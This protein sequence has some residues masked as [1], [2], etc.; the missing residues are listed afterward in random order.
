LP[1]PQLD[2][3]PDFERE[4]RPILAGRCAPCH[5]PGGKMYDRMPFDDASVVASHSAGILKRLKGDDRA[6]VERWIAA[7][8]AAR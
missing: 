1:A 6:V 3:V 8:S 2:L 7:R 5:V 4:V